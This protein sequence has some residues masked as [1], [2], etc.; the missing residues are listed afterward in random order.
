MAESLLKRDKLSGMTVKMCSGIGLCHKAMEVLST[1]S[2][3]KIPMPKG[4]A[5]SSSWMVSKVLELL[6]TCSSDCIVMLA[7]RGKVTLRGLLV[8]AARKSSEVCVGFC[9]ID[10]AIAEP[11]C[12]KSIPSCWPERDEVEFLI[13]EEKK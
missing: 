4:Y 9:C 8:A 1:A 11:V 3:L 5:V 12:P 13:Y 10:A 2:Y 6:E 7:V